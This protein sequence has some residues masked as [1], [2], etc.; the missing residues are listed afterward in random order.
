MSHPP[1]G[2][3]QLEMALMQQSLPE[4][5]LRASDVGALNLNIWVPRIDGELPAPGSLPVFV[6]VHGGGFVSGSASWPQYDMTRLVR[7]S[8]EAGTPV[9]GVSIKYVPKKESQL[10][11]CA[12]RL[13]ERHQMKTPLYLWTNLCSGLVSGLACR[14]S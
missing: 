13:V 2:G 14:A 1:P 8:R 4:P 11:C 7:L 9:V 6:W 3:F 12:L 5:A 10:R